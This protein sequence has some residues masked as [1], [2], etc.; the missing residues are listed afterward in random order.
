[1]TGQPERDSFRWGFSTLGCPELTLPE[2][3]RLAEEF[4]I[5]NIEVRALN[6]RTDLPQYA[7]EAGLS[8][9]HVRDLLQPFQGRIMVAG[10]DFRLVGGE[11]TQRNTL[12]KFC[13]W[14]DTWDIPFVRVFGGG[15]PGSE[16][17]DSELVE[18]I[19]N[20]RWWREEKKKLNWRT[21]ILLETHDALSGAA[22]CAQLIALLDEPLGII[23]DAHHTWR[24]AGESPAESWNQFGQWVRHVHI[25]DS[26]DKPSARHA[27]SYVL[28]GEGQVPNE[29]ITALLRKVKFSGCVSF[30]WEKLWHPYLPDLREALLHLQRQPWFEVQN[31]K[32]QTFSS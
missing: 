11:P 23:W 8:S 9:A 19:E 6:H 32:L 27:Y 28:P 7:L 31:S 22:E 26:I 12:T 17:T 16:L 1:M 15:N 20:V 2:V 25:K 5:R 10:S 29:E 21:E 4:G 3:C 18:A 30:E 13:E 24:I 14:A